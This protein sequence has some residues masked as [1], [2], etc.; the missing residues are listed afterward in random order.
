MNPKLLKTLIP[1]IAIVSVAVMVI[2]GFVAQDWSLCW[3]SLFVGGCLM[4]IL[5]IVAGAQSEKKGKD[6][7]GD[8]K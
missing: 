8:N 3:I 1:I 2:W 7:K 4:G 6:D 5:S